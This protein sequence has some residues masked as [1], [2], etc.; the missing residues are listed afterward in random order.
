MNPSE[1]EAEQ[2]RGSELDFRHLWYKL[3]QNA[4]RRTAGRPYRVALVLR[5]VVCDGFAAKLFDRHGKPPDQSGN[6]IQVASVLPFEGM[7]QPGH[8][9]I[10][11]Q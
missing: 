6:F 11:T 4:T 8:A 1:A 7:G 3:R 10:I 2:I 9:F 5:L